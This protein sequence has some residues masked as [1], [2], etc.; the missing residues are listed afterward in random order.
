MG[1][2]RHFLFIIPPNIRYV[3]PTLQFTNKPFGL[4]HQ[5]IE[6]Y[7]KNLATCWTGS[8]ASIR[9]CSSNSIK[10]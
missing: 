3:T 2:S 6:A 4:W 8:N 10:F 7:D 5:K 9:P 1:V